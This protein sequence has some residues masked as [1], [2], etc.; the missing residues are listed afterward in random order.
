MTTAVHI[1]VEASAIVDDES[2]H[3]LT[4]AG[5][6]ELFRGVLRKLLNV[7]DRLFAQ[8]TS[9]LASY[10]FCLQ[11]RR[12]ILVPIEKEKGARLDSPEALGYSNRA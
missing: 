10:R 5:E 8:F 7:G 9:H 12:I 3:P 4:V 11:G 6:D 2:L 1:R